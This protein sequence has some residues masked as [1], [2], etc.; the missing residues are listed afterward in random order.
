MIP[1]NFIDFYGDQTR[2]FF[3]S[4]VDVMDP[5]KLGRVK[6]RV[7]G[8]YDS[9]DEE[10]KNLIADNDLPWAQIVVPVTTGIHEGK[11]QNLGL[12]VGTQVFGMFL[13]GQNSQLPMV[14]GTVPKK[15]DAN[16]K[17]DANYPTNKVYQTET[18][19]YKEYD[20]TPGAERIKEAHKSGTYYE[21]QADGSIVTFITKDNYSIVL[22]DES[23]TIAGKVTINVGGDVD[24][25]AGGNVSINAKNIKLNS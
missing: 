10:N 14:I 12:L 24:L 23:V 15:G 2:W 3:G 9:K 6:V 4:V 5:E 21:M 7:F 25:T 17:A 19:H 8:V 1:N 13:D 20:D 22:G 11:G 18:G 16:P